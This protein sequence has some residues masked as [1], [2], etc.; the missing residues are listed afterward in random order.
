MLSFLDMEPPARGRTVALRAFD[1]LLLL[2]L[3]SLGPLTMLIG[4]Q[5]AASLT[6]RSHVTV[7][8]SVRP[9][10][11]VVFSDGKEVGVDFPVLREGELREPDSV[12]SEVTVGR[13]DRDTRAVLA[14]TWALLGGCAWA[15]LVALRRIVRSAWVSD[16]F[17][18]A[19]VRRL[20]LL[21][22][23]VVAWPVITRV[24][25]RALESTLDVV[26]LVKPVMVGPGWWPPLLL[27]LGLF[28]L[29]EVWRVGVEL[30]TLEQTT[31]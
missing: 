8:V 4:L 14:A 10:Y 12:R 30:R 21:G 26:P 13:D 3:L 20:R 6:G 22:V 18:C 9:P 28:A 17:I 1:G 16:P 27:G 2:A 7:P 15:G 31:V 5:L 25:T 23:V 11:D 24:S 29:A 19:N